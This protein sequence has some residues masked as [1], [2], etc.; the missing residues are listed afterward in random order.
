MKAIGRIKQTL[1][2]LALFLVLAQL[3]GCASSNSPLSLNSTPAIDATKG[4]I[5]ANTALALQGHPY[6]IGGEN[7]KQGFDCSGLVYYVYSKQGL[8]LPRDTNSLAKHLPSV[9]PELRAPGD[10]LFFTINN[11]SFAH[12]GIYVGQDKFVHA[13][14]IRTGKV[15]LSDLQQPYWRERFSAVR[16]PIL[17]LSEYKSNIENCALN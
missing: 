15:M 13:P 2:L 11:K 6:V 4:N 17:P 16:R 10:L 7:P 9:E 1:K 12:V 14:S 3:F 8:N 5:A